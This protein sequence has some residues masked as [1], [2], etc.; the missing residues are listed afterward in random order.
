M[1]KREG[2]R[3]ISPHAGFEIQQNEKIEWCTWS[4][5][6]GNQ[7][8]KLPMLQV[9][10]ATTAVCLAL[11]VVVVIVIVIISQ[12][13]CFDEWLNEFVHPLVILI[14]APSVRTWTWTNPNQLTQLA[15]AAK[16]QWQQVLL[17]SCRN[18]TQFVK[19][20]QEQEDNNSNKKEQLLQRDVEE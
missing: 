7:I 6:S 17:Q 14:G 3:K 18:A 15:T 10:V 8:D 16:R 12:P 2:D 4:T 19:L 5:R 13:I 11:I 1:W 9:A 20:L